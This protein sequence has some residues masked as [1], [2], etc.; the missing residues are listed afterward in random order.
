MIT[1]PSMLLLDEPTSGLDSSTALRIVHLLRRQAQRGMAVLTTIHQPS[2]EI[3]K[4]FDRIIV[5]SEGYTV[6][7]GPPM[8]VK[9]YFSQFGLQMSNYSNPADKLSIIASVPKT[10]L[11]KDVTIKD[12]AI[13]CKELQK[14]NF[15]LSD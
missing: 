14:E 15:F 8:E 7:N 10:V 12:L 9:P 4:V 6:Y 2:S 11:T 1:K 13:K 5:L 3:F